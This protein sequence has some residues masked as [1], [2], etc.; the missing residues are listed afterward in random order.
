MTKK[1]DKQILFERMG[2]V[3]GMPLNENGDMP[4]N[5]ETMGEKA[6]RRLR[7]KSPEIYNK[8]YN[9]AHSIDKEIY[10]IITEK[11]NENG[12]DAREIGDHAYMDAF[13]IV[14]E[15]INDELINSLSGKYGGL[16]PD[17]DEV[18][19]TNWLY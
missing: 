11:L 12:I 15:S 13:T 4:L 18:D 6:H 5:E 7:S 14:M 3:A 17:S 1:T 19:T 2:T 8:V 16:S 10:G 9:I